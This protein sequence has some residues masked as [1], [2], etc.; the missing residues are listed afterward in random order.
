MIN[1]SRGASGLVENI[2]THMKAR[3]KRPNTWR[4]EITDIAL[5]CLFYRCQNT[6]NLR[7][8]RR[9]EL[10]FLR[11]Y[12]LAS[13]A[14]ALVSFA[15]FITAADNK[16]LLLLLSI[17]RDIFLKVTYPN[18]ENVL[19]S[20]CWVTRSSKFQSRRRWFLVCS[21]YQLDK[22]TTPLS[23]ASRQAEL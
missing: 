1:W 19:I 15:H 14:T 4:A 17:S 10:K 13:T 9:N 12:Q 6:I 2:F 5:R 23:M 8:R 11:D 18:R 22:F 16:S 7:L 3:V 21:A 20:A